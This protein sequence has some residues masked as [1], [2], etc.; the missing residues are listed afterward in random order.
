[1]SF[2]RCSIESI[3]TY[4]INVWFWSCTAAERTALQRVVNTA[5]KIIGHP[6][7]SLA[8]L[9]SSRCLRKAQNIVE[10]PFHPGHSN[11]V[12]LPSGKRYRGLPTRTSRFKNSF[13]PR[14]IT[15]L[16]DNMSSVRGGDNMLSERGR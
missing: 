2:Y 14:A 3:L 16:N 7:P 13:Y 1:M 5:Q 10:D 15:A 6:L 4:C 8:D 11:L 9:Y 12:M